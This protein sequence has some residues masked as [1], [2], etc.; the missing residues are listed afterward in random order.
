[1]SGGGTTKFILVIF[2]V[3]I[4]ITSSVCVFLN[5][6]RIANAWGRGNRRHAASVATN[7]N[8][9]E[10][11]QRRAQYFSEL[12]SRASSRHITTP[13]QEVIMTGSTSSQCLGGPE[14]EI[15]IEV[16][17]DI[18]ADQLDI[19]YS[20]NNE[21][22]NV[23]KA[24]SCGKE[25]IVKQCVPKSVFSL[26]NPQVRLYAKAYYPEGKE[27]N[28]VLPKSTLR[29]IEDDKTPLR[30]LASEFITVESSSS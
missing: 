6:D 8:A 1:M 19:S 17:N 13:Q 22:S 5:R 23:T 26:E 11:A 30:L 27:E 25:S 20:S 3:A 7:L 14:K 10:I 2:L 18:G 24:A 21:F 12:M 28:R 29:M 16:T 4:V 9:E 15:F